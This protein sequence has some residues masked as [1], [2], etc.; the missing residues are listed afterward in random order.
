MLWNIPGGA[1]ACVKIGP[2]LQS[3]H[4]AR[5]SKAPRRQYKLSLHI[6]MINCFYGANV[7]KDIVGYILTVMVNP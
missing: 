3:V 1:C 5:R 6:A 4:M 2:L 7:K